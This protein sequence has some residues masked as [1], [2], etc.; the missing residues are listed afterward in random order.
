[1]TTKFQIDILS[2]MPVNTK[3]TQFLYTQK[4]NRMAKWNSKEG[5]L[6]LH[7]TNLRKHTLILIKGRETGWVP[8]FTLYIVFLLK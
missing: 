3:A 1:M 8:I 2:A 4:K 6:I 5:S 7:S